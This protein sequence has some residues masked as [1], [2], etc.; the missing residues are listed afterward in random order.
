MEKYRELKMLVR[1]EIRKYET[2][3]PLTMGGTSAVIIIGE[4]QLYASRESPQIHF[5]SLDK[6]AKTTNLTKEYLVSLISAMKEK[7]FK[8]KKVDT[9]DGCL[10]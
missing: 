4:I 2:F 1:N 10:V 9:F 3:D 8:I 6:Q 7:K 5:E